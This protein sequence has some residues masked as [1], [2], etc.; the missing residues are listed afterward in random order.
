MK[1]TSVIFV[2]FALILSTLLVFWQVRNFDFINY[3]D[4]DY[5]YENPDV[6][7]GLSC[8]S[9]IAAFTTP[10]VGNWLPL[11]WL[12]FIFDCQLFGL[13]PGRMQIGRAHV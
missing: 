2:Y 8:G 12:S 5:V 13:N 4:N 10:H 9:F 7:K 11:T 3:D 6:S 1:R